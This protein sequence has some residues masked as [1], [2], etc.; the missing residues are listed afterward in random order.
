MAAG[1]AALLLAAC[2]AGVED[3]PAPESAPSV[4]TSDSA[5]GQTKSSG[6]DKSPKK[7]DTVE[8]ATDPAPEFEVE[9]FEGDTFA[10]REEL[11]TPV[12]LNFWESW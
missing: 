11:G 1:A 7:T 10:I 5:D 6:K 4:Q 3:N 9:T 12:V 2:S 8:L